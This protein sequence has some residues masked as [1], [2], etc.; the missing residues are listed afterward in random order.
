MFIQTEQTPNPA[1]LKFLPGCEVMVRSGAGVE[2]MAATERRG[3]R[4][5][6][7]RAVRASVSVRLPHALV[8]VASYLVRP[9]WPSSAEISTSS[10]TIEENWKTRRL[11][12]SGEGRNWGRCG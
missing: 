6:E 12:R 9:V 2:E 3:M 11:R 7:G 4:E 1:S 10:R 5:V 8:A